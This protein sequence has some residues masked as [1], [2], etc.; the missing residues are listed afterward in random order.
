M[1]TPRDNNHVP[2][3]FGVLYS[4][5]VTLIPIA[6]DPTT[7]GMKTNDTATISYNPTGIDFRDENYA[8]A[9]M[10]VDTVTGLP[11]PIFVDADG[12]VLINN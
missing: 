11:V 10:G 7:G 4:D 5:G 8:T 6:V 2:A 12:A 9:W 1:E 3:K